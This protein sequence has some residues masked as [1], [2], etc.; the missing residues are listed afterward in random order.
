MEMLKRVIDSLNGFLWGTNLLVVMLLGV[1]IY[2]T[3]KTRF[4]QFRLFKHMVKLLV[5]KSEKTTGGIS[6]FQA[7]CISTA[8]RVGTGNLAGVVAAIS[9]G[10]PGAIFWMWIV[11]MLGASTG[12]A[13]ATLAQLYRTRKKNGDLTGGSAYYVEK[14]LGNRK[15]GILFVLAAIF[16]FS[17]VSAIT[18]NSVTVSFNNAFGIDKTIMSFLLIAF[19]G[20]LTFGK[21]SKIPQILEKLVPIMAAIYLLL[22]F[23]IMFKNIGIIPRVLGEVVQ[24]AFGF[25][26]AIGGGIGAIVMAGVKRGLFSNEAGLGTATA[27][28]ATAEVSHPVKQGLTQGLGVFVDTLVI[29]TSTAMIML[30][31]DKGAVEGLSGMELLQGAMSYHFG[32]FGVNFIALILFLFSFSTI[33]GIGYYAQ[34]NLNYISDKNYLKI[35]YKI[36]VLIMILFGGVSQSAIVWSLADLGLGFMGVINLTALFILRGQC[37]ESLEDYD[38]NILSKKK[39]VVN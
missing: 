12:F 21:A 5:D 22:V 10:G 23:V 15:F 33:L 38:L 6:S 29:C 17:G 2:F 24:G 7:F 35:G 4:V 26:Q 20:I 27:V 14:A 36:L 25:K 11:G 19:T 34:T 37:L 13:E 31:A 32:A 18:A 30:L 39:W 28:A 16:C 8:S 1:G 9:V 3:V